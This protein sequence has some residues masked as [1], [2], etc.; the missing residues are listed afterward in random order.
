[1]KSIRD[2]VVEVYESTF[3]TRMIILCEYVYEKACS[4]KY[5]VRVYE[6]GKDKW[7]EDD[8]FRLV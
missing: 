2:R 5:I 4:E 1:M 3:K 8:F 7:L 6:K